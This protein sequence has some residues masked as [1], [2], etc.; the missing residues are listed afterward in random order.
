MQFYCTSSVPEEQPKGL[1]MAKALLSQ[2]SCP[3]GVT[4]LC[5]LWVKWSPMVKAHELLTGQM[6]NSQI[7]CPLLKWALIILSS[8]SPCLFICFKIIW[9]IVFN[10]PY[11]GNFAFQLYCKPLPDWD[12]RAVTA[13]CCILTGLHTISLQTVQVISSNSISSQKILVS[14]FFWWRAEVHLQMHKNQST[15]HF[16]LPGSTWKILTWLWQFKLYH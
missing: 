10:L 7:F 11:R 4:L 6:L 16:L 14:E 15:K 13:P 2:S 9:I 5:Q 3:V 8:L 1:G 12:V